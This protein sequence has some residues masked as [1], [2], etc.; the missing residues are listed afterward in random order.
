MPETAPPPYVPLVEVVRSGF[1]EG[2]HYGAVVGLTASGEIGYARGDVAAPMLPRSAAKPFQAAAALR[3]GAPLHGPQVAIAAGSHSGEQR[4]ADLVRATL[5]ASGLSEDDL[6]CPA[7]WPLDRHERDRLLRSGGG[8]ARALMNCSGKHAAMLAA[9]VARGWDTAGYLAPDHPVQQAVRSAIEELCGEPVAH[10]AVDGCGAPQL[11]VSL[12]GLARGLSAMTRADGGGPEGRVLAAMRAHP[13][14]VAGERRDDTRL[15]RALPG[16]VSK[17]GAEGV[18]ALA[19]PTGE[20]VAVKMSD[21]DPL[22]RARTM[23]GLTAL[24]ALG[25]DV[26]PVQD[27]LE[28]EVLGGGAPV[29]GVRPLPEAR[30]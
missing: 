5:A 10:T 1:R 17:I 16:L 2:V 6:G 22:G 21:G 13:E 20:A 29:G 8:P 18:I 14:Y 23:A 30:G 4:H 15:M 26:A 9:C 11:A 12:L 28:A 27:M 24:A 25:V 19:A 7:E 3:A